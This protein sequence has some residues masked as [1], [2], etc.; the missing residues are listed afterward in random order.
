M[1]F[2]GGGLRISSM[3]QS[4]I[5]VSRQQNCHNL[6]Q[7]SEPS[8]VSSRKA[9]CICVFNLTLLSNTC[10]CVLDVSSVLSPRLCSFTW[11]SHVHKSSVRTYQC[12]PCWWQWGLH[13]LFAVVDLSQ[14]GGCHIE[15]PEQSKTCQL[16]SLNQYIAFCRVRV[17]LIPWDDPGVSV[18]V[19]RLLCPQLWGKQLSKSQPFRQLHVLATSIPSGAA[20]L[21]KGCLSHLA[22]AQSSP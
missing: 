15:E 1:T 19:Q 5:S 17:K 20:A 21:L 8:T 14:G 22:V 7:V 9:P 16:L 2:H 6:E 4:S 10:L 13:S 18:Q 3:N 11:F 12:E